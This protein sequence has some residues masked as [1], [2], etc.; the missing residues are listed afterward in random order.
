MVETIA[1]HDG[2]R[3]YYTPAGR[4]LLDDFNP[5]TRV[6]DTVKANRQR[7]VRRVVLANGTIV[8]VKI[9]RVN[10]PR[11]WFRDLWRGSKAK[12]EFANAVRLQSL[13]IPGIEPLAYGEAAGL[14]PGESALVTRAAVAAMPLETALL[15][16][17]SPGDRRALAEAFGRFV[18]RMHNAGVVHPDAHP[19]NFLIGSD[20][21]FT[22]IDLHSLRF[23][24]VGD[25]EATSMLVQLN[26]WFQE[27]VTRAD[28]ARFFAA[29][30]AARA[31]FPGDPAAA[32]RRIEARTL[33]SNL[34]LRQDRLKR[35]GRDNRE[36]HC[37]SRGV[38]AGYADRT[39]SPTLLDLL[40]ADPDAAF[41]SPTTVTLKNSRTSTVVVLRLEGRSYLVKRFNLRSK[42][43]VLK[44]LA[45]P[46]P[47]LRSWLHGRSFADRG[48]PTAVPLLLLQRFTLGLAG[49]G[50][51][52]FE[53]L[54]DSAELHEAVRR[55]GISLH[56]LHR[57]AVRLGTVLRTMHEQR[58][59]HRD[60]K[61]SNVFL[62]GIS[63]PD[64]A[65]PV[66]IDLVGTV[67]GFEVS[68]AVR[69]KNLARLNAG[70]PP[71]TL[72]LNL[73]L[74]VL[75]A[76]LGTQQSDWKAWWR[77]IAAGS[78]MKWNRG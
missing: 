16:Y 37:V 8:F 5:F 38:S 14:L 6:G 28:R 40:L 68:R 71:G 66:L 39:L 9:C 33:Q 13:G 12:L 29:Y 19:G 63:N 43:A 50:L 76:Y 24:P 69:I 31:T 75:R 61:P 77:A 35:W 53:F 65:V 27:R 78:Q 60:L 20:A 44:N 25:R 49:T 57:W 3:V 52:V 51:V 47:A 34:E 15:Q 10:S 64:D 42:W 67:V 11:S 41:A 72:K 45:R 2:I 36:T 1:K 22:L 46:S 73:R 59:A 70:F 21:N 32:A 55:D 62:R 30:C 17:L 23:G 18:A 54:D 56:A 74:R 4:A 7:T 48:L 26:R 58:V